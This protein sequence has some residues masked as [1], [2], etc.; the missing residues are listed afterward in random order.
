MTF[1]ITHPTDGGG[2]ANAID[3]Y[4][5]PD[6]FKQTLK[7]H[8]YPA[9]DMTSTP[10]QKLAI[11]SRSNPEPSKCCIKLFDPDRGYISSTKDIRI[12]EPI[13][14]GVNMYHQYIIL[15]GK[16]GERQITVVDNDGQDNCSRSW[17]RYV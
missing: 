9:F 16:G 17:I 8:V 4:Q 6:T 12:T 3:I 2:P 7:E 5:Y 10:D 15:S 13:S 14:L 11:L 1:A